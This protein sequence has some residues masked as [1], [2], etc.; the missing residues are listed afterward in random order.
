M[1]SFSGKIHV[2]AN[3]KGLQSSLVDLQQE[4]IIGFD[5]ETR[6][7]F[8]RGKVNSVALLQLATRNAV[9]LYRLNKM[10]LSEELVHIL[11]TPEKIKVGVALHD[12]IRALQK[13]NN[14]TPEQFIELSA[15]ARGLGIVTCGLRNLAAIF[16][17]VRISKTAKLSNWEQK[18]LSKSQKS[19]AATD[20]WISREI[21]LFLHHRGWLS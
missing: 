11:T 21:Y 19:Y 9:Y 17:K 8:R 14:F 16:L 15:L 18:E 6:P 4:S 3:R 1:V 13:L 5:T 20:A 10:G 12:D 2:I 7:S